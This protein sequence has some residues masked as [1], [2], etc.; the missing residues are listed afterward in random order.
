L[1]QF[2]QFPQNGGATG[3]GIFGGTDDLFFFQEATQNGISYRGDR[4][5][6]MLNYSIF[7]QVFNYIIRIFKVPGQ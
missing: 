5:A 1:F 3:E 6:S 2:I 7:L 4:S